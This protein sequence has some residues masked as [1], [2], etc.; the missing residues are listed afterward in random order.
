MGTSTVHDE[1]GFQNGVFNAGG[2]REAGGSAPGSSDDDQAAQEAAARRGV[3]FACNFCRRS[4]SL[5]EAY[6]A[7]LLLQGPWG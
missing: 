3:G 5:C 1:E 6:A 7:F 2:L 4:H